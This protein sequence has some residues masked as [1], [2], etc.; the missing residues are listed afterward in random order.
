MA[1]LAKCGMQFFLG[2]DLV[3]ARHD[4]GRIFKDYSG[5]TELAM[6]RYVAM[7]LKGY[8][9]ICAQHG[10]LAKED[11]RSRYRRVIDDYGGD[12][13]LVLR[14]IVE[15]AKVALEEL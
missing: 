9:G 2:T 10:H 8:G 5:S 15:K 13:D 4:P 6:R 12:D 14:R 1:L 11:A 3:Q 7:A